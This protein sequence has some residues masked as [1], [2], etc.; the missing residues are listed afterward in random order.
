MRFT[1]TTQTEL[2][3][4]S[5]QLKEEDASHK[6]NSSVPASTSALV[7][8]ACIS[9]KAT[10]SGAARLNR[11]RTTISRHFVAGAAA[12]STHHVKGKCK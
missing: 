1:H 4:H 3:R 11:D 7:T 5:P 12:V 9:K 6:T 2:E 10:R 8:T